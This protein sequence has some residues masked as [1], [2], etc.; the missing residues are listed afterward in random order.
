MMHANR[1]FMSF[2]L[3]NGH[4]RQAALIYGDLPR[5]A[6]I[7]ID[8]LGMKKRADASFIHYNTDALRRSAY[9]SP[10]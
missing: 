5:T 8:A 2:S 3:V 10:I 6:D 4:S 1:Y 7:L 9:A